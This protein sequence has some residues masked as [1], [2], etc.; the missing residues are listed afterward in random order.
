MCQMLVLGL[1]M[2][3]TAF[4]HLAVTTV[5]PSCLPFLHSPS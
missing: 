2:D 4:A 3:R 5:S 1:G